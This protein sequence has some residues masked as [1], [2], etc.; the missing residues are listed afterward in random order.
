MPLL[1]YNQGNKRTRTS[2]AVNTYSPSN[3]HLV[4]AKERLM[5]HCISYPNPQVKIGLWETTLGHCWYCGSFLNPFGDGDYSYRFCVDHILARSRGGS[6]D[7]TNLVPCC[8]HCNL[9]K[10][11]L[12]LDEWRAKF[13]AEEGRCFSFEQTPIWLDIRADWLLSEFGIGNGAG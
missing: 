4:L 5:I 3:R 9:S 11:N 10:S 6:D 1:A 12:L 8:Y 2:G 7:P 13:L